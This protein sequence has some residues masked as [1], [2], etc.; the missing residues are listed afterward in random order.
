MLRN[1]SSRVVQGDISQ[2]MIEKLSSM[3][4]VVQS[5]IIHL[6][7]AAQLIEQDRDSIEHSD[8]II[9]LLSLQYLLLTR[10]HTKYNIVVDGLS[11]QS[12]SLF[13][14]EI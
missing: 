6:Q 5:P 14:K 1:S 10:T 12:P 3:K 8:E 4:D 2:L 13:A 9:K 7:Y 11:L